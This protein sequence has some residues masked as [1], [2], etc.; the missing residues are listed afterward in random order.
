MTVKTFVPSSSDL[1]K[2]ARWVK[3]SPT[4]GVLYVQFQN[5]E[6][7]RY[8]KMSVS[9]MT[10]FMSAQSAGQYFN[11]KIKPNYSALRLPNGFPKATNS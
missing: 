11:D 8:P 3:N 4:Q 9:R 10:Y 6:V 2:E 1:I 7:Y 5:G